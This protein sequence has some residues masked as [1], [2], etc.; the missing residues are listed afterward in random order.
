MP[1]SLAQ[2]CEEKQKKKPTAN[3]M[4]ESCGFIAL[5]SAKFRQVFPYSE[6]KATDA[7]SSHAYDHQCWVQIETQAVQTKLQ[8]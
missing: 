3:A 8:R 6:R 5:R 2:C 4:Q 1:G 7:A